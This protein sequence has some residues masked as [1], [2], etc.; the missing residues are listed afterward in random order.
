MEEII[1]KDLMMNQREDSSY[2]EGLPIIVDQGKNQ[3]D[4]VYYVMERLGKS[5]SNV[6]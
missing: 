3:I 1:F 2:K 6:I 5:L 4:E